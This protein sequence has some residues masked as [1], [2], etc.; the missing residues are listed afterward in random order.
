MLDSNLQAIL[1]NDIHN[2]HTFKDSIYIL[3]KNTYHYIENL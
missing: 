2:F 1:T 3:T